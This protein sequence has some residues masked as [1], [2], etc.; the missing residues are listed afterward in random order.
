MNA[1]EDNDDQSTVM[2]NYDESR[3]T[4]PVLVRR[5]WKLEI[6]RDDIIDN[7]VR[8]RQQEEQQQLQ[9]L[10]LQP[11]PSLAFCFPLSLMQC[12]QTVIRRS[13]L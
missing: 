13:F 12:R 2:S 10:R 5:L 1:S 3:S 8:D 4:W 7:L 11:L 6:R 9:V